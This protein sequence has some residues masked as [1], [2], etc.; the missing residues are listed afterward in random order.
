MVVNNLSGIRTNSEKEDERWQE[1]KMRR[2][3]LRE[4]F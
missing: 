3:K 4:R 1:V 2:L